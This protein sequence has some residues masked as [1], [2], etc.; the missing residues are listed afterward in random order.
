M[1][2]ILC[3]VSGKNIMASE[4]IQVE[5]RNEDLLKWLIMCSKWVR[6]W[7]ELLSITEI[8]GE[9]GKVLEAK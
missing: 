1:G 9:Y 4:S 2:G 7:M 8:D 3:R 5:P 6:G